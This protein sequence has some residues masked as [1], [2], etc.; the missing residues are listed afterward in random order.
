MPAANLPLRTVKRGGRLAI[1]NLQATPKDRRAALVIHAKVDGV[2][3]LALRQLNI[4]P[5]PFSR[6]DRVV[7]AHR[8]T[9]DAAEWRR[10]AEARG[11]GAAAAAAVTGAA[12]GGGGGGGDEGS[13]G[14]WGFE[15]Q[16]ASP[17]GEACPMPMVRGAEVTFE[18]RGGGPGSSSAV[19]I[20]SAAL[21][22]SAPLRVRRWVA[23][24]AGGGEVVA[25]VRLLLVDAA[26]EGKRAPEFEYA[27]APP[28]TASGAGGGGGTSND[29]KRSGSGGAG[30]AGSSGLA[31][32]VVEFETQRR[33]YTAEQ[34]ALIAGLEAAAAAEPAGGGSSSGSGIKRGPGR[35]KGRAAPARYG[36]CDVDGGASSGGE[37]GG[38]SSG[39]GGGSRT[40]SGR[41]SKRAKRLDM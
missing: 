6:A 36:E 35:P 8:A 13:A 24:G 7:L 3:A 39:R 18:A 22:G 14:G 40:S 2:L 26:D 10:W 38:G 12:A 30:G 5:P 37:G 20:E 41:V 29:G 27:L 28:P 4:A 9:R 32:R 11:D 31:S 23:G 1:V 17:H 25:R 16:I 21:S 19:V 15:L 33:D 34:A